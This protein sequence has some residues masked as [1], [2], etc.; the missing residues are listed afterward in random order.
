MVEQQD[1]S[2]KEQRPVMKKM[3]GALLRN[4]NAMGALTTGISS[5]HSA[6][7]NLTKT[8]ISTGR[9]QLGS[10]SQ[11]HKTFDNRGLSLTD[12]IALNSSILESGLATYGRNTEALN[13]ANSGFSTQK[14]MLS[15]YSNVGKSTKCSKARFS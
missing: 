15:E 11:L 3:T 9:M 1:P 5:L 7:A 2:K 14:K 13:K 6:H 12:S 4:V 10:L 8:L